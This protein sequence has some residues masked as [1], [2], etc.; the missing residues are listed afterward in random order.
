MLGSH[1]TFKI[2]KFLVCFAIF[3]SPFQTRAETDSKPAVEPSKEASKEASKD[4][5]KDASSVAQK[6]DTSRAINAQWAFVQDKLVAEG[7]EPQFI[8]SLKQNYTEKSFHQVIE[9][10]TL[11]A[12]RKTDYHAPQVSDDSVA[13]VRE[14]ILKNKTTLF[15]A[16]SDYS[17]DGSVIAS[18]LFME[19]RYGQNTGSFHVGSVY[20]HL[21]Q[22]KRPEVKVYL[23][24]QAT[25]FTPRLTRQVKDKIA[26]K[27]A[28]KSKWALAE[29][30][31]MQKIYR[32]HPA[33]A[34]HLKGS[35]SGAF[36]MAQ[37]LPSSYLVYAKSET[38][39]AADLNQSGDAIRSVAFYLKKSGF[40]KNQKN[41]LM[42][43]NNSQD[44][45]KA[46]LR[47]AEKADGIARRLPAAKR[48]AKKNK[49][50]ST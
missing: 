1:I 17:V 32:K 22:L 44:Y 50:A 14:F 2:A 45:A 23:H 13:Q 19:S 36:G 9:L 11:L 37:F 28:T 39:E 16:E 21:L 31:A 41:A 33:M 7:F 8:E 15:K 24:T 26:K 30:K 5:P 10:N 43:Y 4:L 48:K 40:K 3:W 34:S 12:L 6:E 18:L 27:I 42:K 25:R 47:L 46:I 49:Q 20:A 29:L 35:F 38:T